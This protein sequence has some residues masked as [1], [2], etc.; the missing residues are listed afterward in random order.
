MHCTYISVMCTFL[1]QPSLTDLCCFW[2][3]TNI[4][5]ARGQSLLVKFDDGTNK[6][7]FAET[8]FNSLSLPKMYENYSE[9][10]KF[11]D[12]AMN[13]GSLGIEHS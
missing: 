9:F 3:A 8:C 5:P 7:P 4:L 11:M 6:L 10:K 1:G 2:T 12:V 13:Y